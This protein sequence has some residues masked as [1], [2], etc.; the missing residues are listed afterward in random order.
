MSFTKGFSSNG[1]TVGSYQESSSDDEHPCRT[2]ISPAGPS[3][4]SGMAEPLLAELGS[5]QVRDKSTSCPH[6]QQ[7]P[8]HK[9]VLTISTIPKTF[10]LDPH[11]NVTI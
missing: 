6:L 2:V 11:S 5:F 3:S 1:H 8:G 7:D 10:V 9:Y 4:D